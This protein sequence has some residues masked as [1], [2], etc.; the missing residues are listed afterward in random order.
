MTTHTL[1]SLLDTLDAD[2][3]L[4]QRHLWLIGLLDWIRGDNRAP[5]DSVSRVQRFLDAVDARP[6]LQVR[7]RTWWQVLADTVDSTM[8]LS[9]YGFS[10]RTA[11]FSELGYR[12]RC[13]LL[14]S[15][16]ETT[17]AAELFSLVL[18][19]TLDAAW[20][21]ALDAAT[22]AR[23]GHLL[24]SPSRTPG[25]TLWQ[26]ELLQAITFCSNQIMATGVA[27]EL[28]LRMSAAARH[29]EPFNSLSADVDALRRA[30]IATPREQ[31][32][33]EA[34]AQRLRERLELCR[35]AAASVYP[36][37]NDH[38]IS[39]NL[40]FML[41]Q[42]RERLLRV[43]DL[44]D[45]LLSPTPQASASRLV[46]RLAYAGQER[47]SLRALVRGNAS[48]LAAKVTERSAETGE[49]YITRDRREYRDMLVK[50]AGGGAATSLTTLLKF[51]IGA[52]GL[53]AFWAGMWSGVMYAA[54]FVMIQ[55]LHWTLATKQPAMTAPAM[56]AKLKDLGN[57]RAIEEF[58]DEVT[59]LVRS[60]VAAV[61]GNVGMVTPCVLLISFAMFWA[62]GKHMITR[63]EADHVFHTLSLLSPSTL[64]FAAFT[65]VLLFLASLIAGAVENWFVLHQLDS[66]LR[67]NPRIT[68]V[69]GVPRADRWARFMREH[70]SGFASNIS[71]GFMLGLLP[72]VLAFV[73]L[74]LEARHV[75]LSTGQLSAAA[76]AYG[77]L[78]WT[79]PVFWWCVAAIPLIGVLNLTVSF[80]LALQ[81]ALGAHSVTGLD[82]QRLRYAVLRRLRQHPL[83]FLWPPKSE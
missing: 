15:T 40:V 68:R 27:S 32:E 11:F 71:L 51:L 12:L 16:P 33:L 70:I 65:G 1:T 57:S 55:L 37:L 75:T 35:Q 4:A 73:G 49:H 24:S 58:V 48:M 66:A 34:A 25:I 67:Y 64:L 10:P 60:Q 23:I 45:C 39:V 59:H 28:R 42:L 79:M 69:L 46:V 9:D 62:G 78:V 76:A 36:H 17:D 63:V 82:R 61:L 56:A 30:F 5:D 21:A 19:N 53:T 43:R 38:G 26:D 50:A 22:L 72:P 31:P 52:V 54:S 80:F 18:P 3:P 77:N 6:E 13:K 44:M 8:V 7:V 47:R 74:G 29:D 20:I 14:P 83:S 81:L 2:A 41:R